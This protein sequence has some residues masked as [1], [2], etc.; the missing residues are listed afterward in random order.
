MIVYP[1]T[2]YFDF[3]KEN[4]AEIYIF[5][6]FINTAYILLYWGLF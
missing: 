6:I 2:K 1:L 3:V 4:I 5:R